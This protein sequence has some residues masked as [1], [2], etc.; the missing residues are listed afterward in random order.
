MNKYKNKKITVDGI[1]FD[2]QLEA[3]HYQH[4]LEL[5]KQGVVKSFEM[6]VP[7]TLLE[8]YTLNGRKVR[9]IKLI[10]DFVVHYSDGTIRYED[11][12][13]LVK[14]TDII[15]KKMFESKYKKELVFM[16]RS[17]IDGGILPHDEIQKARKQRKLN[18]IK[19]I[20]KK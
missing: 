6:Q 17:I 20:D 4:L 18:K 13:G 1:Q 14:P 16:G 10:L 12:K 15:K 8:G 11:S 7:F 5:Q 3:H 9:P 19:N 2:S